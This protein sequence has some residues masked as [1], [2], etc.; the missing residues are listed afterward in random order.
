MNNRIST[1]KKNSAAEQ[2]LLKNPCLS[3][4]TKGFLQ[5][6]L[7]LDELADIGITS[8]AKTSGIPL[9]SVLTSMKELHQYGYLKVLKAT[10]LINELIKREVLA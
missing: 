4:E 9:E 8:V 2:Q 7:S 3:F 10:E 6:L 5:H 1:K